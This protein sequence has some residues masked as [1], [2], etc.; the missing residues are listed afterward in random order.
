MVLFCFGMPVRS[1][2]KLKSGE[3]FYVMDSTFKGTTIEKAYYMMHVTK[4]T[5][6]C[7]QFDTYHMYRPMI[8]SEQYNDDKGT[9]ANGNFHFYNKKGSLDSS[10][11]Y[12]AGLQNGEWY[13]FNDTGRTVAKKTYSWAS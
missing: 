1:Q 7:W 11:W 9:R 6:T 8:S 3:A 2:Q 10:G 4:I 13:F 12:S 5:D